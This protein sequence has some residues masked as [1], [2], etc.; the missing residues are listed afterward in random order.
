MMAFSAPSDWLESQIERAL[1]WFLRILLGVLLTS[2]I[3]RSEF[4][5]ALVLGGVLLI[6]AVLYS[7]APRLLQ[8]L[9]RTWMVSLA[10][11]VL[12]SLAF[13][14]TGATTGP[15]GILGLILAGVLA[16]RF[17]LWSALGVGLVLW[18][19]F[20]FP[21]VYD[22]LA[23][24]QA[25]DLAIL[26][27]AFLYLALA[28][29]INYLV[30][31]EARQI[32]L[33]KD[34]SW[35]FQHLAA[36]HEAT[37]AIS[38]TLDLESLLDLIVDTAVEMLGADSGALLLVEPGPGPEARILR[39]RAIVDPNA[40]A[41][42]GEELPQGQG[43][44]ARVLETGEPLLEHGPYLYD[45]AFGHEMGS[46]LCVPM[47]SRARIIGV[48]QV[49]RKPEGIPFHD[50]DVDLLATFGAQAAIA[51]ENALLLHEETQQRQVRE[52]G[53]LFETSAAI[54]SSLALDDVLKA[55]AVQMAR[56]L[57]VSSCTIS[58]WDTEREVVTALAAE[59]AGP[60]RGAASAAVDEG[61]SYALADY[62][63]TA[64]VLRERRPCVVQ[65]DDPDADP[66]ERALL[67]E[68]GQKSLLLIPL[69]ARDRVVG[70]AELYEHRQCR[71]FSDA[72]IRLGNAL[73]SQAAVSIENARL[74]ERTDERL[75]ARLDELTA[76]QRIT[77]KLTATLDL[78]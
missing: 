4:M 42:H 55:V 21:F 53:I 52:L 68:L 2:A 72:D 12:I 50:Q 18:L 35:R 34:A 40:A 39:I 36:V 19:V 15:V 41:L 31:M 13:Y 65:V 20:T 67:Q 74:Y 27:N 49:G 44:A 29:A 62:P 47:V 28:F 37:R 75:Q 51:L 16:A 45:A 7:F 57:E 25:F 78:A 56:A 46:L 24:G 69:V 71:E 23:L 3:L 63:A 26:A 6:H 22:W 38:S 32:R 8:G 66:A 73:A 48:L 70:L 1:L 54:S 59:V 76:M 33:G 14:L 10:D 9:A 61:Q 64:R 30:A 17:G 43:A 58:D 11:L 5:D 77:R 60:D